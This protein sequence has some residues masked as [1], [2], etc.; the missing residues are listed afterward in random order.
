MCRF[1]G[2]TKRISPQI[3]ILSCQCQNKSAVRL[4][5][6]VFGS[7][8]TPLPVILFKILVINID[9]VYIALFSALEQTRCDHVACGSE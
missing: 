8:L 6:L 7:C 4:N 3:C 2:L 9:R 1:G 5:L